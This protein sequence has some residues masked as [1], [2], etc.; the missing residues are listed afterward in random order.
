MNDI[1]L[2][3]TPLLIAF[4]AVC[5]IHSYIVKIAV[6]KNIVDQPNARKLQKE[7]VP[8]LGGV[9]IFFGLCLSLA[10]MSFTC[11]FAAL[12]VIFSAIM[13]MLYVGTIDDVLDL[14]PWTRFTV[15]VLTVLLLIFAGKLGLDNLHGLFGVT[16]LRFLIMAPLTIFACVGIINAINLIDGV[17]GLSS[18]YCIMAATAFGTVFLLGEGSQTMSILAM[19]V[20]GSL[21]P[22]FMHNV[23]GKSS[24]MFIGDGGTLIMGLIMSVFVMRIVQSEGV[25]KLLDD[26]GYSSIA[27]TLAVLAIPVFDTLRVMLLRIFQ[28]KSPLNPDKTH[29]HHLFIELG[30]SHIVTTIFIV[31]LNSLIIMLWWLLGSLGVSPEVQVCVIVTAS[32]L[33]TTG[34]YGCSRWLQHHSPAT[35]NK[36]VKF[37]HRVRPRREGIFLSLQKW[38]DKV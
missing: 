15:Q 36:I 31:T 3:I 37:N 14:S 19:S 28:G 8:I 16:E 33:C 2:V 32:F 24:K 27:F 9:A 1:L 26:Q 34:I 22:F 35:F 13:I 30:C 12:F 38:I 20:I 23:F 29:L 6:S 4:I 21:I 11:N 5:I 10:V 25:T 7:P 17:D 18:A